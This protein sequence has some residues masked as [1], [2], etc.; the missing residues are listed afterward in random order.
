M[1]NYK[2]VRVDNIYQRL[3]QRIKG[4]ELPKDDIIEWCAEVVVDVIGQYTD[5][6]RYQDVLLEPT[7]KEVALPANCWYVKNCKIDTSFKTSYIDFYVNGEYLNIDYDYSE[8]YIDYWALPTDSVTGYLVIPR[9]CQDA[10]FW[11]CMKALYMEDYFER[12]IDQNRWNEINKEYEIAVEKA[13]AQT[14][15]ISDNERIKVMDAMRVINRVY[16]DPTKR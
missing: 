13:V 2:Y 1:D 6:F 15:R 16:S 3:A 8:I 12:K 10:C 14:V 9:G 11:Y 5:W 4:K 7:D